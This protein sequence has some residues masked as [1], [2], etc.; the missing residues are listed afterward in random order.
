MVAIQV[1]HRK[2]SNMAFQLA[3]FLYEDCFD[4]IMAVIDADMLQN[5]QELITSIS[6]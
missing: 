6:Y 2:N 5:D 3:I 4:A 1:D